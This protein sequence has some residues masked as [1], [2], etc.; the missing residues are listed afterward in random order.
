[1][2]YYYKN[3]NIDNFLAG[4]NNDTINDKFLPNFPGTNNYSSVDA[5]ADDTILHPLNFSYTYGTDAKQVSTVRYAAFQDFTEPGIFSYLSEAPVGTTYISGIFIGGGGGGGASGGGN[6]PEY[7]TDRAGAGGGGGAS[8]TQAFIYKY[9]Y[10]SYLRVYIG[11][12]G[13]GGVCAYKKTGTSGNTGGSTV[14]YK[15]NGFLNY[16]NLFAVSGGVGGGGGTPGSANAN[17]SNPGDGG[18][19]NTVPY[20]PSPF[21]YIYTNSS[22][23]YTINKDI[24]GNDGDVWNGTIA[25]GGTG[26][27]LSR[28]LNNSSNYGNGGQGGSANGTGS[29]SGANDGNGIKGNQGFCRIYY[30]IE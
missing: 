11:S 28:L 22:A 13:D 15:Y 4:G 1:M 30:L 2:A 5:N 12:G 21:S 20:S 24:K 19:N 17:G 9:P 25:I 29:G 8:G 3:R 26:G 6:N 10:Y 14:L 18:S 7:G 16:S 23:G 27:V